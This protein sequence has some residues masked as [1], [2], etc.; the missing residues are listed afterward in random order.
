MNPKQTLFTKVYDGG[1]SEDEIKEEA[2]NYIVAGS[3]T[4][5]V[6]MTY[7]VYRV[8]QNK[9]V[10]EKLVAELANISEPV[11]DASLKVLPYLDQVITEALRLH[12][13]V[14]IALPRLVPVEGATFVGFNVPGGVTV[15]TQSYSL[16]RDPNI[17]PDPER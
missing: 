10:R 14:P 2:A 6:T 5:A 8:S 12:S 1:L 7:L 13:P 17:F 4:T 9:R 3:D 11:T 15:G 16:H